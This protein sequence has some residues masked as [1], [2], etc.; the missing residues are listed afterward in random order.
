MDGSEIEAYRWIEISILISPLLR[1]IVSLAQCFS[2]VFF[3]YKYI[4]FLI[5]IQRY[6]FNRDDVLSKFFDSFAC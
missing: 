2:Y 4:S 1:R 6:I 5:L 3:F